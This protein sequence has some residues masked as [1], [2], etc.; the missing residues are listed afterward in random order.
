M[1][2]PPGRCRRRCPRRPLTPRPDDS[3]RRRCRL[4]RPYR[5]L[6]AAPSRRASHRPRRRPG[7][8]GLPLYGGDRASARS[9][10]TAA[11][12]SRGVGVSG[13]NPKGLLIF[14]ALL[15]Q[16][17]D[18]G[19]RWPA[20]VQLTASGSSSSSPVARSTPSSAT[21][22]RQ[23]RRNTARL[24]RCPVPPWSSS[25]CSSSSNAA[26]STAES[27]GRQARGRRWSNSESRASAG[28]VELR[29]DLGELPGRSA[30]DVRLVIAGVVEDLPARAV[31][32]DVDRC[33]RQSFGHGRRPAPT[34]E[35]SS[36]GW[37][38][39]AHCPRHDTGQEGQDGKPDEGVDHRRGKTG[40]L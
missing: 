19:G 15:P 37:S 10:S 24:P 33:R 6:G 22:R 29:E 12:V 21:A 17:T 34:L 18:P 20:T 39:P 36:D 25:G 32:Q 35:G 16:L 9:A 38:R 28:S 26:S 23:A 27:S 7:P 5:H 1:A 31:D 14:V 30:G 13:L 3:D 8:D 2:A 40:P 4:P 11:I